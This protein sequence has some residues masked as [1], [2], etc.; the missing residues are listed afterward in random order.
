MSEES[1]LFYALSYLVLENVRSDDAPD[2]KFARIL[3]HYNV[4][5]MYVV[6]YT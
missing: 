5:D 1:P 6:K 2:G 3:T 4:Y